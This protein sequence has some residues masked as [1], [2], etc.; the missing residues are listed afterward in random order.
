[1]MRLGFIGGGQ[2][3]EAMIRGLGA[4]AAAFDIHIIVFDVS[5]ER[6]DYLRKSYPLTVARSLDE[7]M[8]S[9]DRVVLAVKPQV[10][11]AV[12]EA[13]AA[14][15]REG[16]IL[17]SIMAGLALDTLCE[18]LPATA[19]CVRLMPNLAMAVGQGACLYCDRN[20]EENERAD[21]IALLETIAAVWPLAE[22]QINGASAISGSGPALFYTMLEGLTLGGIAVGLP[23]DAALAMANQ[24][25]LGT[26]LLLRESD[27]HPAALRD[28]VLSP[29]GTTIAAVEVLENAGFRGDLIRAVRA[30]SDRADALGGQKGGA[31]K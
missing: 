8:Q 9:C 31:T 14:G 6:C 16:Q 21:T 29:G 2:M 28:S 18:K 11:P 3:A 4:H 25:M 19:K 17:L 20:L 22:K 5:A 1:M 30:A 15:Y 24:T 27:A 23:K 7:V 13:V 10:Y 12:A 26:A